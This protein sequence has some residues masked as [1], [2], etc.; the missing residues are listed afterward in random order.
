MHIDI[1][2]IFPEMF[3]GPFRESMIKR[4]AEK[5]LVKINIVD[6]RDYA[7]GKH[8]QV[9]DYP[10]G[11][12]RGMIL[13]PE[14][15]FAAIG[16]LSSRSKGVPY[17]ILL[18]PQGKVFDQETAAGFAAKEHVILLC[19][20]YEGVDERVCQYLVH[21]EISIGD[22]ILT[23]GEIPAMAVTDAMVRLLPGLLDEEAVKDES[24]SFADGLLEY[25]QY[26][27]PPIFKGYPVPDVLLSGNHG[28][29]DEWRHQQ[30]V[31][32][33]RKRRPD[34]LNKR[35]K[36]SEEGGNSG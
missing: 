15:L 6:L 36:S 12:G 2:T 32:T 27:R 33:T 17:V 26:T 20:H 21:E 16:E 34:L 3:D 10:Y 19:G 5:S 35:V 25:P 13:K 23:G 11:G 22:Y 4:A 14:P 1:V 9:D 28:L 18:T 31:D 29:I 24:F 8:R 7:E 30:A